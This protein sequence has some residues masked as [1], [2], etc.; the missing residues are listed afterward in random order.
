MADDRL[1][2]LLG[3]VDEPAGEVPA[4]YEESLWADLRTTLRSGSRHST[5]PTT[6]PH[7]GDDVDDDVAVLGP[8]DDDLE[9]RRKGRRRWAAG[10][11]AAVTVLLLAGLWMVVDSD[12]DLRPADRPPAEPVH[13]APVVD[14]GASCAAFV[15]DMP[16]LV[17]L[18]VTIQFGDDLELQAATS[19][20]DDAIEVTTRFLEQLRTGP[21]THDERRVVENALDALEQARSEVDTDALDRAGRS[22]SSA[23]DHLADADLTGSLVGNQFGHLGCDDA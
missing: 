8:D 14:L 11:A 5:R 19:D 12:D 9:R 18:A 10:V 7:L 21:F 2:D 13:T 22:I 3:L 20:L 6:T 4:D 1:R 17:G 16:D 15:E 23:A